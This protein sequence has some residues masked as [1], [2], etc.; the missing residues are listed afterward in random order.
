[1]KIEQ[2]LAHGGA[3][4]IGFAD[5]SF[6]PDDV[7]GAL[8]RAISLGVALDPTVVREITNGPTRRYFAEYQHVNALL[9]RLCEKA[10]DILRETGWRAEPFTATTEH[11]DLATLSM[12]L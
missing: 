8:P 9:A 6:L 2:E 1:M 3:D 11:F 10:A 7:T 4:F 12:P 5:V